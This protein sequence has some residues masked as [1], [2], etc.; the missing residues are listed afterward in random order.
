MFLTFFGGAR[1]IGATC[2]LLEL[3]GKRI[4]IDAGARTRRHRVEGF[5][6]RLQDLGPVDAILVTHA[7]QD[8]VGSIPAVVAANPGAPVLCTEPTFFLS[9][10]NWASS[11]WDKEVVHERDQ[12]KEW[13]YSWAERDQTLAAILTLPFGKEIRLFRDAEI[14]ITYLPAG[15][16]LGAASIVIRGEGKTIITS[17]DFSMTDQ[18]T[19]PGVRTI[20][21][22]ALQPD[23]L[24][25]ETTYADADH[26][27]RREEEEAFTDA[28][29]EVA[30]SGANILFPCFAIGRAQEVAYTLSRLRSQRR[31]PNVPLFV[32]GSVRRACVVYRSFGAF[33]V[34]QG[35]QGVIV[36]KAH[37]RDALLRRRGPQCVI[38]SSGT[39]SGGPSQRYAH[40]WVEDARNA[41]FFSGYLDDEAPGRALLNLAEKKPVV[42]AGKR[43]TPRCHVRRFYFSAH[44]DRA[45]LRHYAETLQPRSLVLHHG[46]IEPMR[47]FAKSLRLRCP[48]WMPRTGERF[49]PLQTPQTEP[50]VPLER[51]DVVPTEKDE[52]GETPHATAHGP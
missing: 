22:P 49:D 41:I 9:Q 1:E 17:G 14:R 12:G 4:L 21:L 11:L 5:Y 33:P 43:R 3:E 2:Y 51:G 31:I 16:I 27:S 36:V 25:L 52:K 29:R 15:H 6:P 35:P 24:L 34:P 8:H 50:E 13:K 39:L 37:W 44:A 10:I 20:E 38:A 32:D 42:I 46:F 23:V 19:L 45:Q 48:I 26:P 18:H 30:R 7:H 40:A 47:A 28:V